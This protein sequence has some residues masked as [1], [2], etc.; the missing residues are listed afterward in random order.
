MI[1]NKPYTPAVDP[2]AP[3]PA[4][5]LP[6]KAICA[7]DT[8]IVDYT[9]WLEDGRIFDTTSAEIAHHAG[10][11]DPE[12]QYVPFAFIAGSGAVIPGFDQAVIG[13]K[14]GEYVNV[15]LTPDQAYGV[16]DPMLVKPVPIDIFEKNGIMPHINDV[17]DC[18]GQTV[19]IDHITFCGANVSKSTVYVDFNHPL[20]GRALHFMIIVRSVYP[21]SEPYD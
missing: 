5:T 10:I 4:L 16:Y 12:N 1:S 2:I 15:A 7:G 11:Y 13:M 18:Q 21:K 9:G 19:R 3:V 14:A 17:L 6:G 20:G 8:I